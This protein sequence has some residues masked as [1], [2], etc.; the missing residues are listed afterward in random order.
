MGR[1]GWSPILAGVLN[2][3]VPC[4][5]VFSVALKAAATTDPVR[6]GALMAA[7]GVG[8]LPTMALVSLMGAAL[9]APARGVLGRLAGLVVISLG[10]WTV[11]EGF[12][13]FEIMRGLGNW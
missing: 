13:F 12:V 1:D 6:A 10:L 5:L 9:G 11:Y 7:F 4:S 8:T 3:W 2:G